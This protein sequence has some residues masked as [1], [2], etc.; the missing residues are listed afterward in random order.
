MVGAMN[1]ENFEVL[2]LQAVSSFSE[3]WQADTEPCC[4]LVDFSSSDAESELR[5]I[6]ISPSSIIQLELL[7]SQ[8]GFSRLAVLRTVSAL[9]LRYF[10]GQNSIIFSLI[11]SREMK[12]SQLRSAFHR[13]SP[14]QVCCIKLDDEKT[15]VEVLWQLQNRVDETLSVKSDSSAGYQ[16]L[17]SSSSAC[18]FDIAMLLDQPSPQGWQRDISTSKVI[19]Q[20]RLKVK[21]PQIAL[22]SCDESFKADGFSGMYL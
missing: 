5:S 19:D 7:C 1:Q 6:D 18:Q 2:G 22:S 9:V 13:S 12:T 20:D 16:A 4:S 14:I 10:S 3:V 15:V 17:P 8:R 21:K 11:S